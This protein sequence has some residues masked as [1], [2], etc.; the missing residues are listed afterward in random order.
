MESDVLTPHGLMMGSLEALAEAGIDIVPRFYVRFFAVYPEQ[1]A[2]F[3]NRVSSRGL[4]VNDMVAMLLA[5][6]EGADW[7]PLVLR[8]QVATHNDK[9]AI[10]L[11]QYRG[12]LDLLVD[13]LAEA[14]AADWTGA[15]D[16]AWRG[17]AAGVF[18]LIERYY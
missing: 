1:E 3:H 7:L 16:R 15:E 10:V 8:A 12:T 18:A 4:M 11:E 2:N 17:A 9:A 6:A 13:T 5:Q 14:A